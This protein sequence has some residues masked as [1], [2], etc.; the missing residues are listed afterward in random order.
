MTTP[1]S[2]LAS[3]VTSPSLIPKESLMEKVGR[4]DPCPCGSGLKF[5]KCHG[6]NPQTGTNLPKHAITISESGKKCGWLNY[7]ARSYRRFLESVPLP[8]DLD[9]W[10]SCCRQFGTPVLCLCCG[11]G[12]EAFYMAE[13]GFAVVGVDINERILGLA[14]EQKLETAPERKLDL[15]FHHADVVSLQLEQRF[16]LALMATQSFQLLLTESDQRAFLANIGNHLSEKG[17][18]VFDITR[19]SQRGNKFVNGRGEII[20]T[21]AMAFDP[22][23]RFLNHG[24]LYQRLSTLEETQALLHASGFEI[25]KVLGRAENIRPDF[26]QQ[27]P[28]V[29]KEEEEYT[30]FARKK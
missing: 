19:V 9:F 7:P 25:L 10:A 29:A 1:I 28:P 11:I 15:K 21:Y 22:L 17:I 18:F 6:N 16:P 3:N 30:I 8:K 5:K 23:P 20:G 14:E 4:N 27:D 26:W 24:P 2:G 13:Q 12:R